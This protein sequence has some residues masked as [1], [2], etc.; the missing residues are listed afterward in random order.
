MHQLSA[1]VHQHPGPIGRGNKPYVIAHVYAGFLPWWYTGERSR[2]VV[3]NRLKGKEQ[4]HQLSAPVH[5]HPGPIGWDI[6]PYNML[7]IYAGLFPGWSTGECSRLV[8][9]NRLEGKEQMHQLSAPVHQHPG[10]IGWGNTPYVIAHVYAGFLP[11]WYTGECS[12]LVV[13]NRLKG[14]EQ[15]HQ[16]SAPVHQHPGPIGWDITPYNML[17]IYAGL[18]PGWRTGECSRL[19][20]ENRLKGKEQMHQLSAPVH[21]H[22]G[23]I[24]WDI[25]PYNMLRIYA[26]LFPGWRTGECSRL[27]VG[28]RL[29][30]EGTNAPTQCPGPPTS[31]TNWAGQQAVRHCTR[32]C[33]V[34]AVVVHERAFPACGGESIGGEGTNAPTQCPGPPTSRTNWVGHH[35]VRHC[36]RICRVSAVVVHGRA[37]P[38]CGGESIEGEGT[39]APTQCPG[40]PTSRT[41]WV[42]HHAVQ[43]ATYIRRVSAGV[44]HGRVF[45]ACGGESIEGE[46]TNAPTQCPGP[47]T[48]RTNWAVW[49]G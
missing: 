10:P 15:M 8:V 16:L 46:G 20:V 49:V 40:P 38:A 23:P 14:K 21:Q 32:I 30:G 6:T 48:S 12:R 3:E 44:E 29:E 22:P 4:M 18:F 35:A 42:G 26:G 37:F 19:V 33:R 17:R 13:E 7:R 11:W 24:G 39:N 34:S 28:N 25:T 45:P 31:R 36:T 5:Q 2:L 9:E 47:P 27:V 43:H 41:N 1:P